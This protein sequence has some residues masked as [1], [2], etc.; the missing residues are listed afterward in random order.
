MTVALGAETLLD[1]L[2]RQWREDA[3]G[4]FWE[5]VEKGAPEDCWPWRQTVS[6]GG[7]GVWKLRGQFTYAH[8]FAYELA[9]GPIPDGLVIDH[10]CRTR[11][12]CNPHH[13]EAVTGTENVRRGE[14]PS[15]QNSRKTHCPQGHPYDHRNTIWVQTK[16]QCR[17]CQRALQRTPEFRRKCQERR[18]RVGR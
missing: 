3:A 1:R 10:L 14:S 12:C 5:R 18:R 15:A 8:R 11:A 2:T 6:A 4:R 7:Y 16:R 13:L 17:A 9:F